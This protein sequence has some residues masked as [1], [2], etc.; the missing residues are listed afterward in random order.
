MIQKLRTRFILL[1]M[2]TLLAVLAVLV[3]GINLTS[4]RSIVSEA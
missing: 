3:V 4:Y 1:S 2:S